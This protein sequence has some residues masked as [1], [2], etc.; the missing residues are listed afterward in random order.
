MHTQGDIAGGRHWRTAKSHYCPSA[1]EGDLHAGLL[2]VAGLADR[3]VPPV[4]IGTTLPAVR[5]LTVSPMRYQR[6]V[7]A[8]IGL[9]RLRGSR[10]RA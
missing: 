6:P 4:R 7:V 1:P 9:V 5:P 2:L 8:A 10:W 3:V